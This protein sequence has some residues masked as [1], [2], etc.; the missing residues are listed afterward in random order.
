M[1]LIFS[2]LMFS[3]V[4]LHRMFCKFFHA[5][6]IFNF[7]LLFCYQLVT[8]VTNV[9]Y[10]T[11]TDILWVE[12]KA[13]DKNKRREFEKYLMWLVENRPGEAE[14]SQITVSQM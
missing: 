9:I 11:G 10:T 2:I 7:I 14:C 5:C 8:M 12:P 4:V 6:L 1:S 3:P 13:F